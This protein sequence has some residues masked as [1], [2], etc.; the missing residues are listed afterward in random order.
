M[1][2]CVCLRHEFNGIGVI[3]ICFCCLLYNVPEKKFLSQKEK[4]VDDEKKIKTKN[5]NFMTI[6]RIIMMMLRDEL[7]RFP[8]MYH[9]IAKTFHHVILLSPNYYVFYFNNRQQKHQQ[10]QSKNIG[11][12]NKKIFFP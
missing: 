4:A 3:K 7:R 2:S 12:N 10:Q 5:E 8:K 6:L 9:K 1:A 11:R